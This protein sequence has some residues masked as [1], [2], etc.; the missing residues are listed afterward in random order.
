[1]GLVKE[2]NIDLIENPC[3]GDYVL[4]HAGCAIEKINKAY[5]DEVYNIF[6]EI[7][8]EDECINE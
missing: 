2:I 1:M 8:N 4:I 5:F 6:G 3:N 7:M